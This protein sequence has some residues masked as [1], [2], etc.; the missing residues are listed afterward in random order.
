MAGDRKGI[1]WMRAALL[2]AAAALVGCGG[3]G[4]GGDDDDE[5]RPAAFAVLG[6]A[7]F[8]AHQANRGAPAS[9]LG[10]AQPLGGVA[11]DGARFYVADFGN[12]RVLGWDD[13]PDAG[14]GAADFVLGQADFSGTAPGTS[15]MALALP[16]GIAIGN[17]R[18]AVADAGNNR[19]L[20]WNTL[21]GAGDAPDV[22]IGQAD[23]AGNDP[24]VGAARLNFPV[25]VAL[26]GNRLFVVD[27][28]NHRV[29]IWNSVPT[30][31]GAA[32]D[33]VLGQPDFDTVTAG[34]EEEGLDNPA[35]LWS[36][37]FR[38]LVADS[39]NNRVMYWAQVPRTSGASASYVIGQTDFARTASGTSSQGM[40]TPF[41]VASD[42]TRIYV[43]DSSNNRVLRFDS[44]PIASGA[45]AGE[46]YGQA[47]FS[48]RVANDTD[49]D[50]DSDDEASEET[51]STPTGVA[52][53]SGVL[54]VTD[55]NNHRVLLFP[56]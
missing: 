20:I 5:D 6:Q 39:G 15:A 21:P 30:V 28:G 14:P 18:F 3:G 35:G 7:D 2:L 43:A 49:E 17:G 42:G 16:A 27:Q 51:L 44:F 26:A 46:V 33:V 54:Y 55:R 56:G 45:A 4:G 36:D 47:T 38:L 50:G 32:A 1:R 37:G 24:G 10:L 41:G 53:F 31:S 48:S 9:A 22:V 23:F 8:A 12:N 52:L 40:F 11:T 13:I 25:A 19:V 29:L 34:D